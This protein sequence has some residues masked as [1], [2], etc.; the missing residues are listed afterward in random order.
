MK[1]MILHG[2]SAVVGKTG[3]SKLF[4]PLGIVRVVTVIL[5]KW[6]RAF[7]LLL[8][9]CSMFSQILGCNSPTGHTKVA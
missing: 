6:K 5:M 4:D 1:K 2:R 9:L 7:S 8:I 3:A